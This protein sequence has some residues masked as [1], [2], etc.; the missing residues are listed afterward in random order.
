[1]EVVIVLVLIGSYLLL[2]FVLPVALSLVVSYRAL[3]RGQDCPHCRGDTIR[4]QAPR[5]QLLDGANPFSTLHRRWCLCCGWEGT[6]RLP[7]H[8]PTV[9]TGQRRAGPGDGP[10]NRARREGGGSPRP[11]TDE[12]VTGTGGTQTLDVRSLEVDGTPWRVMLQCWKNT[13]LYYGRF[14]FVGPTGR[15]WL[16]SVESFAGTDENDVLGQALSLPDGTLARRL[17]RLVAGR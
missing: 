1:M 14:V 11:V 12:S 3:P 16:D 5:L 4:L 9:V 7:R 10:Q 2:V 13:D 17:R 8:Q 6:C 15:L